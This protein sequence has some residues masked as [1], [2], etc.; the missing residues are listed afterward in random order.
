MKHAYL[1]IAHDNFMVLDKLVKALDYEKNDIFVHFDKK[2][3][4]LPL[5]CTINSNLYILENRIDVRWGHVSQIETEFVLFEFALRHG[6]YEYLHLVSGTHF[7][8]KSQAEIHAYFKAMGS[9]S[10]FTPIIWSEADIAR[11]LG[12]YHFFLKGQSF[13]NKLNRKLKNLLW[14]LLFRMQCCN[15]K[16]VE[17]LFK[18]KISNWVS[19][20]GKDA[21]YVVEQ[22]KEV[23]RK[24]KYSFCGDELFLPYIFGNECLDY[25]ESSITLYQ[26]FQGASPRILSD[27]NEDD[28]LKSGCLFARKFSD[29]DMGIIDKIAKTWKN[30]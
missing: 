9:K 23:L 30:H 28:I 2:V 17:E 10:V 1:I 15:R 6:D 8:L 24:F 29:D 12:Y 18:G 26:I 14:R 11:K 5:L 4:D 22:R 3:R 20:S 27:S 25:I 13:G 7:P 21:R 16:R 19:L